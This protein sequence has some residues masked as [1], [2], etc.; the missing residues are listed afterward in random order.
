MS[1]VL[2][3]RRD[4]GRFGG[5]LLRSLVSKRPGTASFHCH[6]KIVR[7]ELQFALVNTSPTRDKQVSDEQPNYHATGTS[8]PRF[9]DQKAILSSTGTEWF[10]WPNHHEED[11][12]RK[13]MGAYCTSPFQTK[14]S[15]VSDQ[16]P[17]QMEETDS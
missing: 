11:I 6:M 10:I 4:F 1:R 14:P 9:T 16:A 2:D 3:G 5:S 13:E 17:I 12:T 7:I 8:D 15:D